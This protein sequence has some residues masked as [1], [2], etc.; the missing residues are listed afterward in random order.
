MPN[1]KN[2][3]FI[4]FF[5]SELQELEVWICVQPNAPIIVLILLNGFHKFAISMW[6]KTSDTCISESWIYLEYHQNYIL[7]PGPLPTL[8]TAAVVA[9]M[10]QPL[11]R[12]ILL[13][14]LSDIVQFVQFAWL[15]LACLSNFHKAPQSASGPMWRKKMIKS[16]STLLITVL[17]WQNGESGYLVKNQRF[18]N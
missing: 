4:Y 10:Q 13:T 7:A 2:R 1:P 16:L 17:N 6:P 9:V 18:F 3:L 14:G 15:N 12:I 5:L 11:Q 8:T